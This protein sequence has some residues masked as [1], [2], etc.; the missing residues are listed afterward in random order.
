M[1]KNPIRQQELEKCFILNLANPLIQKI[2]CWLDNMDEGH[3]LLNH[4]KITLVGGTRRPTY[5]DY[6]NTVNKLTTPNDIN[7]IANSDIYFDE[8]G[9]KLI[10]RHIQI[11]ECYALSRWD[12]LG[13]GVVKLFDRPDSQDVWLFKGKIKDVPNSNFTQARGGCDNSIAHWLW[14]AGYSVVNPS[15]DIRTYHLHNSG[16]RNYTSKDR[17]LPPYKLIQPHTLPKYNWINEIKILKGNNLQSQ[18]SEDIIIGHIFKNINTTNK[19]FVDLGAGAY[20]GKMSNTRTLKNNG[21]DGF[22]VD[23]ANITDTWILK[24]F[25][26]PDNVCQILASQNTPKE[27]DFLNLDLDSSD[28]WVL[29]ELLKEY[30]PRLICTEFNGVLDPNQ[31]IVLAYEDGYTWDNT[32][33]YGY[34]FSAGKKLLEEHGYRI[35]YNLRDTNLFAVKKELI[36]GVDFPEVTAKQNLYHPVNFNA[37]WIKY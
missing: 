23:C 7:C 16:I 24:E 20:D 18:Y 29:K 9:I 19:Y 2:Y 28:F 34:S 5:K 14:K 27:F 11:N 3:E 33:K 13:E 30:S 4:P 15:K 31:S 22:G 10:E 26:K 25:V 8:E 21:W 37:V 1:D 36:D 12:V 32:H 35:I 17:V 6:F